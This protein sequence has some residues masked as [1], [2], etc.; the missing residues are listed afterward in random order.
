MERVQ[1]L[2]EKFEET[3]I[4]E[5]L[6][7]QSAENCVKDLEKIHSIKINTENPNEILMYIN[8]IWNFLY[9]NEERILIHKIRI[10]IGGYVNLT[11]NNGNI[12]KLNS[13]YFSHSFIVISN[14]DNFYFGDSWDTIHHFEFRRNKIFNR[15]FLSLIFESILNKNVDI[16]DDFFNDE[17]YNNWENHKDDECFEE[18]DKN[19]LIPKREHFDLRYSISISTYV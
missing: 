6:C 9:Q 3:N 4:G 1:I 10:L 19:N 7:I 14:G 18:Y 15:Y 11:L 16:L 2:I 17:E 12:K 13:Q 8:N 5:N